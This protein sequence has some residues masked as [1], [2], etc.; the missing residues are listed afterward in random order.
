MNKLFGRPASEYLPSAGFAAAALAFLIAASGY[1]PGARAFPLASAFALLALSGL[2]LAGLSDTALGRMIREL[3]NPSVK[4]RTNSA[5][6]S[7]QAAVMLSL[8]GLVAGLLLLGIEIAIPLY[9]LASLRFRARRS[10]ISSIVITA[11]VSVA[12]WLLFAVALRLDLYEG[13]LIT[14]FLTAR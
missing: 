2:D 7:R 6:A 13:Y 1:P 12:A 10:W 11:G 5:P 4:A 3:L 8:A 9:L 14:R